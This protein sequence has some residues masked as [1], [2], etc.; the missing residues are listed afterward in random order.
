MTPTLLSDTE[1]MQ[2][3]V[4]DELGREGLATR[5]NPEPPEDTPPE[6]L[7]ESLKETLKKTPEETL[8]DTQKDAEVLHDA[9]TLPG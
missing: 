9:V 6:S 1:E 4:S 8:E 3:V 7:P 2:R 5:R